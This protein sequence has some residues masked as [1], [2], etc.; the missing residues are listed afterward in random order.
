MSLARLSHHPL[1]VTLLRL[2]IV[3]ALV[4]LGK[5][6]PSL[7]RLVFAFDWFR[8]SFLESRC[9]CPKGSSRSESMLG[10]IWKSV[11][12]FIVVGCCYGVM[13]VY[14]AWITLQECNGNVARDLKRKVNDWNLQHLSSFV[15][16]ASKLIYSLYFVAL[17]QKNL[18]LY[19]FVQKAIRWY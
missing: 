13:S 11:G 5:N 7:P 1:R 6:S 10:A 16:A 2:T 18:T 9:C 14:I 17:N 3:Q 8:R 15:G 4:L 12:C 19:S